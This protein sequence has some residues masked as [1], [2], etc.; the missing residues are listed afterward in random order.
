MI[1]E[2]YFPFVAPLLLLAIASTMYAILIRIE[3][4]ARARLQPVRVRSRRPRS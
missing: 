2:T 4:K 1:A 3:E